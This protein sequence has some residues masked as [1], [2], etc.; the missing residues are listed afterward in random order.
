MDIV[1][2]VPTTGSGAGN[3][4]ANFSWPIPNQ[5]QFK[6]VTIFFTTLV[7]DLGVN[8]LGMINTNGLKAVIQ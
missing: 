8:K 1:Q 4:T 6:G 7:V 2:T 5:A 3:G